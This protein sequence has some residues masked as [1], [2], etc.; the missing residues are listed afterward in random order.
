MANTV[1]I[2]QRD[3]VIVFDLLARNTVVLE[4]TRQQTGSVKYT[5]TFVH[6]G[7]LLEGDDGRE[8][9]ASTV[10]ADCEWSFVLGRPRTR[11]V[12]ATSR[13]ANSGI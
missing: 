2:F 13:S 8:I 12:V 7:G 6:L 11:S 5:A 3:D 1:H 4:Y 9:A 10:A